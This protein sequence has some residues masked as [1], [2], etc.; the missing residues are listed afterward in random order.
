[1][2]KYSDIGN[3]TYL[4]SKVSQKSE[5]MDESFDL[6]M[7]M[8][9]PRG[10]QILNT[11]KVYKNIDLQSGG[12]ISGQSLSSTSLGN[13]FSSKTGQLST[14]KFIVE[15][16][17]NVNLKVTTNYDAS[18]TLTEYL[19]EEAYMN[20]LLEISGKIEVDYYLIGFSGQGLY[21]NSYETNKNSISL[22]QEGW[23]DYETIEL[24]QNILQQEKYVK[25]K[26]FIHPNARDRNKLDKFLLDHGEYYVSKITKGRKAV[27]RVTFTF[28]TEEDKNEI[29]ARLNG[30]FDLTTLK[31]EFEASFKLVREE[32]RKKNEN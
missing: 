8:D 26:N 17:E 5:L 29:S 14:A 7:T 24:D 1:M 19:S 4:Q 3:T 21:K 25:N 12:I 22:F 13:C 31:I 16:E 20:R 32:E 9:A 30:K 28:A 2:G 18:Y 27:R 6:Q 11:L 23:A 15:N 10:R